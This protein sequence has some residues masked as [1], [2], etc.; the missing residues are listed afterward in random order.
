MNI[1]FT[2]IIPHKNIP[3]LL[4]R[5]LRSI[6]RRN[7]VQIIV[8]DDNS[9]PNIV[10]FDNF[11]GEGE[12]C[13]EVYKIRESRGAGYA[14]NSGLK[15]ARG[16][17]LLFADADDFFEK[18]LESILDSYYN[19]NSDII[20]FRLT[21]VNS[22][23]L[24]KSGR[25]NNYRTTFYSEKKINAT[26]LGILYYPPWGRMILRKLVI[27][28]DICF[29]ET[30]VSNDI[31]FSTKLAIAQ[32]KSE[33]SLDIL[34]CVTSRVGSLT[35]SMHNRENTLDIR[36]KVFLSRDLY[37]EKHGY[38]QYKTSPMYL[39]QYAS[40]IGFWKFI[41]TL[42]LLIQS[43]INLFQGWRYLLWGI[44][45]KLSKKYPFLSFY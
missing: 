7:D 14:R 35:T 4:I 16:K 31:M 22:D 41:S 24:E 27:E 8:V 37:L 12:P 26:E 43:K 5:C 33:V 28:N 25:D 9:D 32:T 45:A 44:K 29:D 13:V 21:S 30:L 40:K 2:F 42:T 38:S 6:P 1:N 3:N 15:H 18:N 10:D 19:S 20:Y 34:Y 36:L 39:L 23:T 17:W 11:P